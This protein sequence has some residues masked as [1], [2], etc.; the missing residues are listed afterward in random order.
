MYLPRSTLYIFS[1]S[2]FNSQLLTFSFNFLQIS[3][4]ATD[5]YDPDNFTKTLTVTWFC[6]DTVLESRDIFSIPSLPV[7]NST[8]FLPKVC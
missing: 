7:I 3:L 4:N 8:F 2:I 5:S 1:P 6:R